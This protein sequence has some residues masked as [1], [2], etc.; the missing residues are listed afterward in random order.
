MLLIYYSGMTA[1]DPREPR[2]N[3]ELKQIEKLMA[4]KWKEFRGAET[5]SERRGNLMI[6]QAHMEEWLDQ[7]EFIYDLEEGP[8]AVKYNEP[9]PVE[10]MEFP[11][12]SPGETSGFEYFGH[13]GRPSRLYRSEERKADSYLS[14]HYGGFVVWSFEKLYATENSTKM[15]FS[16]QQALLRHTSGKSDDPWPEINKYHVFSDPAGCADGNT[17]V[18]CAV[19][20]EKTAIKKAKEWAEKFGVRFLV[21]RAVSYVDNH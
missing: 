17:C 3:R 9:N 6:M 11:F 12:D 15:H 20:H 8:V 1:R 4:A 19:T 7:P 13:R 10:H 2:V 14:R 16:S 21:A 5:H 18:L